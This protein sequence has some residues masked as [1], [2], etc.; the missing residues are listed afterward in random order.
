MKLKSLMVGLA[1]SSGSFAVYAI[2]VPL[3]SG[4]VLSH[5]AAFP[6]SQA[7][8]GN[9]Q[10]SLATQQ[11]LPPHPPA[12][13]A[14]FNPL[15]ATP[16]QLNFY[17]FP[18]KPT[19][20]AALKTWTTAMEHAKTYVAPEQ[21]VS[22]IAAHV[23]YSNIWAGYVV[24]SSGVYDVQSAW[25]QPSY[26][27][28]LDLNPSD[29][30]F[31]VGMGGWNTE[32]LVQAGADSGANNAGGSTQYEFWV[33]DYS[34]NPA[35]N[36]TVWEAKPIVY[37]GDSLYVDVT[38]EG[39]TSSAYLE[40]E[41]T[42]QYTPVSFNTPNYDGSTADFINEAVGG[43]YTDWSSWNSTTFSG[44]NFTSNNDGGG[45]IT[46]F[47]STKVIMT[48]NGTSSGTLE[49]QPSALNSSTYGFTVTAY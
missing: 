21:T 18:A 12:P 38:Y 8:V 29:P 19:D 32:N 20:P 45:V 5:T 31:W 41:T 23:A 4:P 30:S 22:N 28:G 34:S 1:I 40:N 33:E 9:T 2:G 39:S 7:P 11:S 35:T 3:V 14:G 42:G 44:A 47:P 24:P 49:S 16:A 27:E 13:P 10:Q 25:V 6:N 37:A 15:H 26:N 48:N 46:N 36:G 17:G 43:T